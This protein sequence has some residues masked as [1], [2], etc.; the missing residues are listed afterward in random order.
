[1]DDTTARRRAGARLAT[2]AIGLVVVAGAGYLG[3]AAFVE[4]DPSLAVGVMALAAGTGFAAFFSPCSFPLLLTFLTRRSAD[5]PGAALVSAVRIGGGAALLLA[6][7]AAVVALGGS[8]LA[9]VVEFDSV[10]GRLFRLGVGLLLVSLGLR[11][12][13]LWRVEMLWLDPIA[14]RAARIFDPGRTNQFVRGDVMYGFGY[15]LAGFG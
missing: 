8:A 10:V 12:A 7:V 2:T 11:Q 4:S 3:F 13:R 14:R 6:I 5:S 9:A 1:M 15:L